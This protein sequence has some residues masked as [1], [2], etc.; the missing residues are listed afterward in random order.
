MHHNTR[1]RMRRI[2]LFSWCFG[3]LSDKSCWWF[4]KSYYILISKSWSVRWL[5][6]TVCQT[7]PLISINIAC[8]RKLFLIQRGPWDV[9]WVSALML[10]VLVWQWYAHTITDC[11]QCPLVEMSNF[12]RIL[13]PSLPC[14]LL[15]ATAELTKSDSQKLLYWDTQQVYYYTMFNRHGFLLNILAVQHLSTDW[16]FCD[17]LR[18][19]LPP[20]DILHNAITKWDR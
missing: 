13:D 1:V 12:C 20:W 9:A 19:T 11:Q 3:F 17:S 8:S 5:Y 6:N 14:Y 4:K 7:R 2:S 18:Y 16:P 15:Q 10:F